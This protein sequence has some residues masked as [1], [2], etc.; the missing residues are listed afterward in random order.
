MNGIVRVE[1]GGEERTLRFNNFSDIELAKVL[2]DDETA[3][4]NVHDFVGAIL[5]LNA[6][7]HLLLVKMLVYS[8]LIGND[9][10]V[11]FKKTATP[12]EV[13]NWLSTAKADDIKKIW[14]TF[15]DAYGLTLKPEKEDDESK[16]EDE[17]AHTS[18]KKYSKPTKKSYKKPSEKSA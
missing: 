1:L 3:K 14:L 18:K 10:V 12:E 17:E 15:M 5:K 9:Y 16:S 7:N 2:F 11:G 13:G 6:E 4:P 8:G